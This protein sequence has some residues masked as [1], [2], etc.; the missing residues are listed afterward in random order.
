[1]TQ[2]LSLLY[3]APIAKTMSKAIEAAVSRLQHRPR[4]DI[5]VIGNDRSSQ[6]YL[7]MKKLRAE[8]IGIDLYVHLFAKSSSDKLIVECIGTL[9]DAD[10]I[11][12]QVPIPPNHDLDQIIMAIPMEKNVD[13]FHA[14]D[15]RS[16]FA[17]TTI[18]E[19]VFPAALVTLVQHSG[20]TLEKLKA[21]VIGNSKAFK[22][23]M[24]AA[25]LRMNIQSSFIFAKHLSEE[26]SVRQVQK[27][28]IVISAIGSAGILKG[29]LFHDGMVV[30]DGGIDVIN[31][32]VYGDVDRGSCADLDIVLSPVPGGV[33][34]VTIAILLYNVV[35]AAQLRAS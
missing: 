35:L 16:S 10:G 22:N 14:S 26:K 2:K 11:M 29:N 17:N 3:G 15:H 7:E 31:E 24:I 34:P 33:G 30:I 18:F 6:K 25:L 1:M 13:S 27:A 19:P 21:V 32:K 4:L 12:V 23:V 5:I 20:I 28:D 8:E 9:D